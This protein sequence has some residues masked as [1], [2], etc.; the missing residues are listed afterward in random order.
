MI[1][2]RKKKKFYELINFFSVI[3]YL[4]IYIYIYINIIIFNTSV[5]IGI[6]FLGGCEKYNVFSD[7]EIETSYFPGGGKGISCKI[8]TIYLD[9]RYKFYNM[10]VI[11][12]YIIIIILLLLL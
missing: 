4:N 2:I 12:I 8:L 6:S 3:S 1:I 5:I 10:N 9:D 11:Y 7:V